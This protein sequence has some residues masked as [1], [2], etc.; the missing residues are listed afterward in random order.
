MTIIIIIIIIISYEACNS[1]FKRLS[2]RFLFGLPLILAYGTPTAHWMHSSSYS[3]G[4]DI[5]YGV[6]L[7]V[8][9]AMLNHLNVECLHSGY[10]L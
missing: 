3:F 5:L 10:G 7:S 8:A 2:A 1:D 9:M 6:V 4:E